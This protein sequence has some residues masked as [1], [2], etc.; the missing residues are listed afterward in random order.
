MKLFFA[1]LLILPFVGFAQKQAAE[2][3]RDTSFTVT[4]AYKKAVKDY[5]QI[6]PVKPY[7]DLNIET[8]WDMIYCSIGKR[9]LHAD[10]FYPTKSSEKKLPGVILI[11]GGGWASGNKSHL[12]PLA[13]KLAVEGFFAASIEYRLSP[14]AKY[15]AGVTDLKTAIKWFKIHAEDYG[16]DT[17]KIA[18]L[19]TSAGGTLAAFL[20]NTGGLSQFPPHPIN[21]NASDKVQALVDIDGMLDFTDPAE[22]GKDN[23]PN[24]PSAAARWFGYTFRENPELWVEASPNTYVGKNTPATLFINSSLPRFHAGREKYLSVLDQY[25][26]YSEV[27]TIENTPHPFWLFHPWFDEAV[28]LIINFLDKVFK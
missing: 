24:K 22:S 23:D 12:V 5:P 13:Q 14:E 16:L 8:D 27:H 9:D 6:T 18:V 25:G 7:S 10:V 28:P 3:P 17:S 11:H 1:F 15:P 20:A 26:I 19:G 4:S 21:S 2:F